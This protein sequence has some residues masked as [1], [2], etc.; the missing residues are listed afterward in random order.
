MK[1]YF[2]NVSKISY[3]GPESKNPYSFKYYNPD[4]IIGNKSM[5]EHLRFAMSYWHTL[6]ADGTDQFGIGT[7]IRPWNNENDKMDLAKARMEAAFEFM[8]KLDLDYFCFHDRDIAPEGKDLAE[9]DSNLDEIVT[10]CKDLMKKNNKKLLWGTANLFS[11]PRFVHGAG[12]TCNVNVFA[13][14]AGQLKKAI[15]ITKELGGENY[16]FWGGREGYETLLNTDMEFELDNFARLLHMAVDYAKEIGFKGQFLI[17]P[18]PKEPTKH[19]YDFDVAAVLAFLRKYE[20]DK[21]FKINI[22]ANHATLAG[23]TFQHE[24]QTAR[25]NNALG[26]LDANQGD[27]NLGWDT[28][29]FPTNIYDTTLAMYEVLKNGGIEPGGLNFDAKVRRASF[30]PEDLFLAYIAG[31][32]TFAKGLRVAY[33]LLEDGPIENFI[34]EKYSSFNSKIGKDII[35]GKIGFNELEKYALE[36][37]SI[38]N[39]SGRQEMLESIVNQYILE[40]K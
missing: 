8:N 26:S 20:L 35:E 9:T 13:Y 17:E 3:E 14:A 12:T 32:D 27:P 37:T 19:Q 33:K 22:E 29:Q 4:E 16:V 25:I 40:D 24:I 23:H 5:R 38:E 6:T 11:N 18:K 34:K 28:D 2:K 1:E 10:I 15:E 31:M 30:E 36:N 21:Y 39:K 7:M